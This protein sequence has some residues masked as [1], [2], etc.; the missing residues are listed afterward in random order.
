MFWIRE[1]DKETIRLATGLILNTCPEAKFTFIKTLIAL[2]TPAFRA[3]MFIAISKLYEADR[4]KN[5]FVKEVLDCNAEKETP[6]TPKND[7][8]QSNFFQCCQPKFRPFDAKDC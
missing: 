7:I 5:T 1:S 6:S 4:L 3:S 2:E 8:I